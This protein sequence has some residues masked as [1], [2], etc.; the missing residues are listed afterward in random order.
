MHPFEHLNVIAL[1][2]LN[3]IIII[4]L[5]VLYVCAVCDQLFTILQ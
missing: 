1:Y 4:I 3:I 2:K 5:L